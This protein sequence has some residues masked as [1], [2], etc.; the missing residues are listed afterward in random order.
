M[1]HLL[2]ERHLR[3]HISKV[4]LRVVY[5]IIFL[6]EEKMKT[7]EWSNINFFKPAFLGHM[8]KTLAQSLLDAWSFLLVHK[9][10]LLTQG[11]GVTLL[12]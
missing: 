5:T 9:V 11:I 2:V 7:R 6:G 4:N 12:N 8:L 10:V 3:V 1:N